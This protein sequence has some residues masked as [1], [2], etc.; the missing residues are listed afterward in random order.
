VIQ[1][2]DPLELQ[3]NTVRDPDYNTSVDEEMKI[4][5]LDT[6]VNFAPLSI[7]SI[8]LLVKSTQ[9]V[10]TSSES[11][12]PPGFGIKGKFIPVN[13]GDTSH[14]TVSENILQLQLLLR[15]RDCLLGIN[16]LLN[17]LGVLLLSRS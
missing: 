8:S 10:S 17:H 1:L 15:R 16:T 12:A 14:V 2:P 5:D 11:S 4:D 9:N 6:E 3:F 7:G 13:Q